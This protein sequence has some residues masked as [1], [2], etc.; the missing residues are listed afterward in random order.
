MIFGFDLKNNLQSL[1]TRE[2]REQCFLYNL[3][4]TCVKHD[5]VL[6]I[7]V[8]AESSIAELAFERPGAIMHKHVTAKVTRGWERLAAHCTLVGFVLQTKTG[9]EIGSS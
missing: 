6:E 4:L 1:K 2:K 9:Q 3:I 7:S 8:L 5:V